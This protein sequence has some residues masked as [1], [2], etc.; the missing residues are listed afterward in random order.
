MKVF[1]QEH[2]SGKAPV[3]KLISYSLS[4]PVSAAVVGMPKPE[5][6]EENIGVAKAF[7]PLPPQEMYELSNELAGEHKASIDRFFSDHIDS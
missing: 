7:R 3:E 6:I 5:M 1:A 4:L 2:L